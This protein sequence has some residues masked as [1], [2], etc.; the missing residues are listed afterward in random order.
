APMNSRTTE[1]ILGT[2]ALLLGLALLVLTSRRKS[3]LPP[4][5]IA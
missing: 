5:P 4:S 3:A 1:V 2:G